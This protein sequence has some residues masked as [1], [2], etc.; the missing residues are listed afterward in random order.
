MSD[1]DARLI[2]KD[3]AP[4]HGFDKFFMKRLGEKQPQQELFLL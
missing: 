4:S 3:S 1:E 2:Y